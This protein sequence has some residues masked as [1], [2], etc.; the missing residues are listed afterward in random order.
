MVANFSILGRLPM[1][2]QTGFCA[3][4]G[5]NQVIN[6]L[7]LFVHGSSPILLLGYDKLIQDRINH[8]L[9]K[10]DRFRKQLDGLLAEDD[11]E[12]EIEEGMSYLSLVI[13]LPLFLHD[14]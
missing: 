8:A 4:T 3:L 14:F 11:A 10:S 7:G 5:P 2:S 9:D 13:L 1:P 6:F 12:V